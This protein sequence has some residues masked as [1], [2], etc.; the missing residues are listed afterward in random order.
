MSWLHHIFVYN[1][2]VFGYYDVRSLW[3]IWKNAKIAKG[4]WNINNRSCLS[5]HQ[6]DVQILAQKLHSF[7]GLCFEYVMQGW[8]IPTPRKLGICA[9]RIR[10]SSMCKSHWGFDGIQSLCK[11]FH[12]TYTTPKPPL[13]PVHALCSWTTESAHWSVPKA[14]DSRSCE[15][16]ACIYWRDNELSIPIT[17]TESRRQ[18]EDSYHDLIQ[19]SLFRWYQWRPSTPTYTPMLLT[20]TP[21]VW[22]RLPPSEALFRCANDVSSGVLFGCSSNDLCVTGGEYRSLPSLEDG[23]R[24]DIARKYLMIAFCGMLPLQFLCL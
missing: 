5:H 24:I 2:C 16:C 7:T 8:Q 11:A 17:S 23:E 21:V 13:H 15:N 4:Q 12:H 1:K 9:L 18:R 3:R 14:V 20:F 19:L 10:L 22:A 6:T